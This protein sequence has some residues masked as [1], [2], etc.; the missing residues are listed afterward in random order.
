[1]RLQR[2]AG[3]REKLKLYSP[4]EVC[5]G[6][7][8]PVFKELTAM[9]AVETPTAATPKGV[10][11]QAQLKAPWKGLTTPKELPAGDNDS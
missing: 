10:A 1:M 4:V 7:I 8:A 5:G 9:G 3:P 11:K 2:F 6:A